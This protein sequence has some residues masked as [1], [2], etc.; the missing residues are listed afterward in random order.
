MMT[1]EKDLSKLLKTM[2]PEH[3][4]GEYVFCRVDDLK[5]VDVQNVLLLFK[6][7]KELQLLLRKQ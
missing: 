5:N 6:E 1:G 7:R 3:N 4:P 2:K